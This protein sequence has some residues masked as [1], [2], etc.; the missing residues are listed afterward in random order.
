MWNYVRVKGI[1]EFKKSTISTWQNFENLYNDCEYKLY[2]EIKKIMGKGRNV[3]IKIQSVDSVPTV[4]NIA[5]GLSDA[6]ERK[7]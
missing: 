4:G 1:I 5:L 3:V 2:K 6:V 7:Y